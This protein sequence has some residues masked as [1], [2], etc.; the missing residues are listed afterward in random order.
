M[1]LNLHIVTGNLTDDPILRY[2]P[3]G[4]AVCKITLAID[5][6]YAGASG[7]KETDFIDVIFWRQLAEVVANYFRKGRPIQVRGRLESRYYQNKEGIRT[8]IWEIIGEEYFFVDSNPISR[9]DAGS[10]GRENRDSDQMSRSNESVGKPPNEGDPLA[11]GNDPF[12]GQGIQVH[13]ND[14][15]LPF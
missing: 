15:D 6:S 1:P 9:A 5:R 10:S 8:K 13:I 12:E 14:D 3:N 11:S 4:V 2:T 7:K